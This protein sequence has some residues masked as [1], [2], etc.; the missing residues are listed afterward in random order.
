[1]LPTRLGIV[2]LLLVVPLAAMLIQLMTV[3]N[4]QLVQVERKLRTVQDIRTLQAVLD[5]AERLRDI[6][7]VAVYDRNDELAGEYAIQR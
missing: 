6:S 7:I 3:R 2:S 5:N 4:D 1:M